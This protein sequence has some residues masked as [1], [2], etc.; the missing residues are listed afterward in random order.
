LVFFQR[1]RRSQRLHP[2]RQLQRIVSLCQSKKSRQEIGKLAAAAGSLDWA[3]YF[4]IYASGGMV[5]HGPY[6]YKGNILIIKDWF[7]L[8]TP[9]WRIRSK[10]DLKLYLLYRPIKGLRF[11]IMNHFTAEENM[12]RKLLKFSVKSN[13]ETLNIKEI[14]KMTSYY[15]RLTIKQTDYVNKL[16][17]VEIITKGAEIAYFMYKNS[18]DYYKED[19]HPPKEVY[20]FIKK[21]GLRYWSRYK[22]A[23]S[24][25][26]RNVD[27]FDPRKNFID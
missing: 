17:P 24:S 13:G 1:G 19:W 5:I 22:S 25:P 27:K 9:I 15:N 18:F 26:M 8:N 11:D 14:T 23:S 16:K 7:G 3:L 21:Q 10:A 20:S 2:G 4:D 12:A 6:R